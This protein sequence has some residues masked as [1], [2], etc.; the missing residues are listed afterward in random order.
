MSL[1][2]AILALQWETPSE[3]EGKWGAK[4]PR[5]TSKVK[6]KKNTSN[7]NIFE[8]Y[9]NEHLWNFEEFGQSDCMR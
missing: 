4:G 7:T 5:L 8:M 2:Q 6:R 3:S 9:N 1:P